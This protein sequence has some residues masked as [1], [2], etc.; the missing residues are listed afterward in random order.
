MSDF[1]EY[2]PMDV[3]HNVK[4]AVENLRKAYWSNEP[5]KIAIAY[6]EAETIIVSAICH[7]NYTVCKTDAEQP[8]G[9]SISREALKEHKFLTP[10]FKVVGG[11][12]CGKTEERIVEAYQKGWNDCIDAIIDNAPTVSQGDLADEVLKLYE[13]YHSHLATRVIEFGDELKDLLGKYQK[14]G[15]E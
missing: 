3:E 11:R 13:K 10:Q 2:K 4:A 12:R 5:E 1:V 14:G 9:D 8:K 6:T 7:D 15:K